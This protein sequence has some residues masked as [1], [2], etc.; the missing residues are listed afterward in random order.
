M[1]KSK[2]LITYGI[3]DIKCFMDKVFVFLKSVLLKNI[4]MK[5]NQFIGYNL[6]ICRAIGHITF[7]FCG[8]SLKNKV[9]EQPEKSE[10]ILACAT[11]M[12]WR[13]MTSGSS[14]ALLPTRGKVIYEKSH[15]P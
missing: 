12:L 13:H 15:G 2:N 9:T 4:I 5:I 1:I 7:M 11:P 8:T 10:V 14:L 6:I 3:S